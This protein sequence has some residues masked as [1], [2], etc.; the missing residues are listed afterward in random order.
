[1]TRE[2]RRENFWSGLEAYYAAKDRAAKLKKQLEAS[3]NKHWLK[4]LLGL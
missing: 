4:K 3:L 1:M 2:E